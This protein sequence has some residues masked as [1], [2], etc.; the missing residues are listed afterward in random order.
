MRTVI[1]LLFL[2]ISLNL[3]SQKNGCYNYLTFEEFI[4]FN[5]DVPVKYLQ[6]IY[7]TIKYPATA[8]ENKQED[9]LRVQLINHS[10]D[11][12]EIIVSGSLHASLI[13]EVYKSVDRVNKLVLNPSDS[14]YI[15]EF[16]IEFDLEPF[17]EVRNCP[18]FPH[19]NYFIIN[20]F[21][22]RYKRSISKLSPIKN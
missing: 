8:R 10:Q 18:P 20:S 17:N 12:L 6:N 4:K 3:S 15:A 5:T 7:K 21:K 9:V 22:P 2:G 14:K 11:N 1:L 13:E 19:C 16:Y